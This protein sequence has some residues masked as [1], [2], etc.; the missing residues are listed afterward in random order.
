VR[1]QAVLLPPPFVPVTRARA[2]PDEPETVDATERPG[3]EG[4]GK[5]MWTITAQVAHSRATAI[6]ASVSYY[7]LPP[8]HD[9]TCFWWIGA[10][11]QE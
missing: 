9:T 10:A 5:A 4:S 2:E 1:A 8:V 3:K 7:V 11:S 6:S